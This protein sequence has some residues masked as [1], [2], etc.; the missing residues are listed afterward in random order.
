MIRDKLYNFDKINFKAASYRFELAD[1]KDSIEKDIESFLFSK[2]EA[3]LNYNFFLPKKEVILSNEYI[4]NINTLRYQLFKLFKEN[5]EILKKSVSFENNT[6]EYCKRI[7]KQKRRFL[8]EQKKVQKELN[9]KYSN[10]KFYLLFKEREFEELYDLVE[11]KTGRTL[12]KKY[13]CDYKSG[14]IES[15]S[16]V[17]DSIDPISIEVDNSSFKE[18]E[19]QV[20]KDTSKIWRD[21][22]T[23]KYIVARKEVEI[24]NVKRKNIPVSLCLII[25]YNGI[26]S[27]NRIKILRGS[28]LPFSI[29][30]IHRWDEDQYVEINNYGVVDIFNE[31][32]ISFDKI[33]SKRIK[34]TF[35][36][37]KYFELSEISNLSETESIINSFSNN[38]KYVNENKE[39]VKVYDM[40]IKDIKTELVVSNKKGFYREGREVVVNSPISIKVEEE[41]AYQDSSCYVEKELEIELYGEK[42]F[43]AF[44]N[45]GLGTVR[46]KEIIP[47]PSGNYKEKEVLIFS[48]KEAKLSFYPKIKKD[49]SNLELHDVINVY[50]NGSLLRMYSDYFV[51]IDEGET[52]IESPMRIGELEKQVK[53]RKAG[54]V[55]IK[56]NVQAKVTDDYIAEYI[57][58]EEYTLDTNE[59]ILVKNGFIL[60]E[61]SLQESYGIVRPRFM[62]RNLNK[63]YESS[64]IKSYKVLIEEKE[65]KI[66][67]NLV[68]RELLKE[69]ERSSNL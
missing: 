37:S 2:S 6:K 29:G 8:E 19:L 50:K 23:F 31:S 41:Y 36:Q 43:K 14:Y 24:N 45:E 15:K 60:F 51:S 12:E 44:K 54:E 3:A 34:I 13:Q 27:F 39:L 57:V 64:I 1:I 20:D 49:N 25:N 9:S 66:K 52:W 55:F 58:S 16:F 68:V 40:S 32:L 65:D 42:D 62:F 35:N 4:N 30:S 18:I 22:K 7:E 48:N 46:I 67:S 21:N 26:E 17:K 28:S 59:K 10:S 33:E 38:I 47:I 11:I 5:N 53:K 56:I 63:N 61:E 69:K